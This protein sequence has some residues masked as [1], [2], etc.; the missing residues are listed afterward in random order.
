M[1]HSLKNWSLSQ[2]H[3]LPR[4]LQQLI[5]WFPFFYF[6]IFDFLFNIAVRRISEINPR[7]LLPFSKALVASCTY[8][9]ILTRPIWSSLWLSLQS[10]LMPS[11]FLNML[12]PH[13][14]CFSSSRTPD[15][16][17]PGYKLL[18]VP[19]NFLQLLMASC[20]LSFSSWLN[21]LLFIKAFLDHLSWSKVIPTYYVFQPI[22]WTFTIFGKIRQKKQV[23]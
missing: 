15:S 3:H 13:R 17:L 18:P 11:P 21:Y 9:K 4:Y 5:N 22:V 10:N 12:W 23:S 6:Y 16:Y 20:C 19:G 14:T 2:H 1:T 7:R 8:N